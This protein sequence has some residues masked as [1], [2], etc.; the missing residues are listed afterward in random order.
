MS[1][2]QI[3][4]AALLGHEGLAKFTADRNSIRDVLVQLGNVVEETKV[5]QRKGASTY[6]SGRG[7]IPLHTDHPEAEFVAWHC[8][9][10][11]QQDGASVLADG[12]SI[13]HAMG[14][15]AEHL[16]EVEIRVP[17]QL[18]RQNL[19]RA[20]VWDGKR[21]YYAPWYPVMRAS[22]KGQ[23]ALDMFKTLLAVGCGH[24]RIR[25]KA[26]EILVVDNGRWL[27]GRDKLPEKSH[28]SLQRYWIQ[29]ARRSEHPAS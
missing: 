12:H 26:G 15:N 19:D 28:R 7:A 27:H 21:L 11:D 25:L 18:P 3:D 14:T 17:P 1:A 16:H 20:K 29:V 2:D 8:E 9:T 22:N 4:L 10:Q 24:R 23:H 13:I 5:R 6:L